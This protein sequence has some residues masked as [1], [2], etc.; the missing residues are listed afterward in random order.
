MMGCR[1]VLGIVA[2]ESR[3]GHPADEP[4]KPGA[5]I[6]RVGKE[7][8]QKPYR[9]AVAAGMPESTGSGTRW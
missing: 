2:R 6:E 8:R 9:G 5:W 4:G 3:R 1:W 7:P